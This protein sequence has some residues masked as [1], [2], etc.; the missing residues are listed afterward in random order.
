VDEHAASGADEPFA[1]LVEDFVS[2]FEVTFAVLAGKNDIV[3][4]PPVR[5]YKHFDEGDR[6]PLTSG[7]GGYSPVPSLA[8]GWEAF[9]HELFTR[10]LD[11]MRHNGDEYAGYLNANAIHADGRWVVLEF[12]CHMGDP[13]LELLLPQIDG[14]IASILHDLA[15]GSRVAEEVVRPM[16]SVAISLVQAGYPAPVERSGGVVLEPDSYADDLYLFT[17]RRIHDHLFPLGGRVMLACATSPSF[18][19]AVRKAYRTARAA[20]V[21]NPTLVYRRDLGLEAME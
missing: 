19:E 11:Y 7:M 14:D 12:N 20:H 16:P 13:D 8:P 2:G 4:L 10:V 3:E 17:A 18:S 1:V 6:G 5:D 15:V 21:V 9:A